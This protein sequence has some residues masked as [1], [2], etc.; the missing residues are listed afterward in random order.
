MPTYTVREARSNLSRLI[1]AVESGREAE[2]II[3][4][5][6]KPA[7]RLVPLNAKPVGRRLGIAEG[8]FEIPEDID[9]ANAPIARLFGDAGE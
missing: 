6:G 1:R 5:H 3:A 4:R 9:G 8:Q 2:I 7:A